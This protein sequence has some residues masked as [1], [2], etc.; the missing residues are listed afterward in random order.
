MTENQTKQ[1][2]CAALA[3]LNKFYTNYLNAGFEALW[4]RG[5]HTAV[6]DLA[7]NGPYITY[8]E[9]QRLLAEAWNAL[10][11]RD[12]WQPIE[13]AP[14]DGTTILI[15][16]SGECETVCWDGGW[17][18]GWFDTW[19]DPV[20]AHYPTHWMPMPKPPTQKDTGQ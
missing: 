14:K 15:F 11:R 9:H 6:D 20:M 7:L 8:A 5:F 10:P 12:E 2:Q 13:T 18:L 16:V 1:P 17:F 3:A 4:H 19:D